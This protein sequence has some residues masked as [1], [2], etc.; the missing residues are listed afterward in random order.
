MGGPENGKF[1]SLYVVKRSLRRWVGGSKKPQ[2]TL[3]GPLLKWYFELWTIVAFQFWTMMMSLLQK[4]WFSYQILNL[5]WYLYNGKFRCQKKADNATRQDCVLKE[6]KTLQDRL[7]F[8]PKLY[9]LL[10][11]TKTA[12]RAFLAKLLPLVFF[13]PLTTNNLVQRK[14]LEFKGHLFLTFLIAS[15]IWIGYS[16]PRAGPPRYIFC[17]RGRQ[18]LLLLSPPFSISQNPAKDQ[19]LAALLPVAALLS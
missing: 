2:N 11:L 17:R 3:T 9:I 12:G 5:I 7:H 15:T 18:W 14:V 13:A 19:A 10:L 16:N 4:L 1:P 6:S 8:A